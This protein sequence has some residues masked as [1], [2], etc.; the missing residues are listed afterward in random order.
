MAHDRRKVIAGIP[1]AVAAGALSLPSIAKA[2]EKRRLSMVTAW[3]RETPGVASSAQRLADMIRMMS[4]GRLDIQVFAAGEKVPAFGCFDAVAEGRAD[5]AHGTAYY[6]ASRGPSFHFF[7]GVPFGLTANE[8]AAWI[9]FG[10]GRE[11]WE[12]AY[13]PYGVVPFYAGSSG[14]QAGG[15]FRREIGSVDDFKGLKMRI[16]GLGGEVLKRLGAEV[17]FTPAGEIVEALKSG[18]V[19]AAEWVGPWND[20]AIGLQKLAPYYYVPAF[21]EFGPS[22]ELIVNRDVIAS[23]SDD[24]KEIVR[25]AACACAFETLAEFT[26]NNALSLEPLLAE[27][28]QLRTMPEDVIRALARESETVLAE[29]ATKDDLTRQVYDS[30]V[31]FRRQVMRWSDVSERALYTMRRTG[32]ME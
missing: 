14:P 27:G 6:W 26:Y 4:N 2:Q 24:L 19:D 7:T 17:I 21:H 13:A 25:R 20:R 1:L 3:P 32:L 10:G 31:T 12:Y 11:T 18:R 9:L 29:A 23:L 30:F 8:H 22:L 15:W 16:S 28:V 5:M